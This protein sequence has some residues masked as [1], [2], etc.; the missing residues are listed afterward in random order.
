MTKDGNDDDKVGYGR[1]PKHGQFKP[2][3]SGNPRGR[4]KGVRN[5]GADVK[6]TLEVPVKLSE[7]GRKRSASTQETT[8]LK[9]REMALKGDAKAMNLLLDLA[10]RYNGGDA[11]AAVVFDRQQQALL[12]ESVMRRLRL[13][14]FAP[15]TP[16]DESED[17]K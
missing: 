17:S 12:A 11:P 5:L 1:P 15:Q 2:G 3:Q 6:R 9:L 8:L 14:S 4:Q 16:K 10:G 7:H 13:S